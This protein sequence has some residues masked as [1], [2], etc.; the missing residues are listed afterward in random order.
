MKTFLKILSFMMVVL[1]AA[2][3][4]KSVCEKFRTCEVMR[5]YWIVS[6]SEMLFQGLA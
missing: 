6:E 4:F 5:A 3:V 1:F 2:P